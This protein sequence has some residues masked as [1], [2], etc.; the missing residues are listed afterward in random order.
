MKELSLSILMPVY[1]SEKY[2]KDTIKLIKNQTFTNWELIIVN[3]GSTDDSR[4]IC[5][6][7]SK[8]DSRIKVIHKEN[9]G[10]S[11]TRNV[12]IKNANGKY[13]GFVDSDDKIHKNMF[14]TLINNIEKDNTDL[15][16]CGFIEERIVEEKLVSSVV[17]KYYPK[18][19]IS[20]ENMKIKFMDF[21]NSEMLNPLW[22]KVYK[23][24]IIEKYNVKFDKNF[25]TGE[26]FIFNLDYLLNVQDISFCNEGFYYYAK[27]SNGSITHQYIDNMYGKGIEIHNKLES[28]LKKIN[29]FTEENKYI[30]AGNHLMGV[31]SAF[32]NLFHKDCNMNLKEKKKY[33]SNI[34]NR[35]Y[36]KTCVSI[37][38][39]DK[40]LIG[41]T[42]I[43]IKIKSPTA[44]IVAFKLLSIVRS[45]K[46]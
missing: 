9:T 29:I 23:R 13:I 40:G 31:F 28:F 21:A 24:E 27:R 7:F 10:V 38:K 14:E 17:K 35:D 32:L 39:K 6:D 15:I 22:N 3:D 11:D 43:L 18:D 34:I 46:L 45:V 12:A 36:V 33:I 30:L 2:I 16:I 5:E 20:M 42:S 26:D 41:I 44:I 1:N 4:E 37:R 19:K 8:N 25:K